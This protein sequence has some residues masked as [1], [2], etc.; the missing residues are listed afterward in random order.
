M[1]RP[2]TRSTQALGSGY[3]KQ[4]GLITISTSKDT[5]RSV[6]LHVEWKPSKDRQF[7]VVKY[8]VT[9][10]D[11]YTSTLHD[12]ACVT[13]FNSST[14]DQKNTNAVS[15][16]NSDEIL[17]QDYTHGTGGDIHLNENMVNQGTHTYTITYNETIDAYVY[18]TIIQYLVMK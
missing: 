3:A 7:Y 17:S 14:T 18:R 8:D 2:P 6:K 1:F 12:T 4:Y 11:V 5:G 10:P 15:S 9:Y 13:C 16:S